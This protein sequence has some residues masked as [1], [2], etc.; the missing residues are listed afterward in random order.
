[1]FKSFQSW[2]ISF[3]V[4]FLPRSFKSL[5]GGPCRNTILSKNTW[6]IMAVSIKGKAAVS[7]CFVKRS[8]I[9]RMCRF[10]QSVAWRGPIQS[11]TITSH[12]LETTMGTK[13]GFEWWTSLFFW[14][15]ETQDLIH[16]CRF[17]NILFQKYVD[18]RRS[19]VLFKPRW[20]LVTWSWHQCKSSVCKVF[21]TTNWMTALFLVYDCLYRMLLLLRK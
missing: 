3:D 8:P 19:Y 15:Q 16:C 14:A 10:S 5:W 21:G 7:M 20:P 9:I 6:V 13:G 18:L 1:M 2:V 12:R 11:A 17:T 4:K